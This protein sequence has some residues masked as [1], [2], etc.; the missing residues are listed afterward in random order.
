MGRRWQVWFGAAVVVL[1]VLLGALI[2][3]GHVRSYDVWWHLQLGQDILRTHEIGLHDDYSHSARGNFRPPQQWVFE[4]AEAV[5]YGG[6]GER[7]LVWL[8]M[9]LAAA[10]PAT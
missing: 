5:V 2:G 6:G 10:R 7:G 8:R 4:V 3:S 1:G 9:A